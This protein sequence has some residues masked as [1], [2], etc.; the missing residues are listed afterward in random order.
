M[1]AR[2]V[3]PIPA[4]L[5]ALDKTPPPRDVAAV[6]RLVGMLSY[7][8][9]FVDHLADRLQPLYALL[10]KDTPFVWTAAC[11]EAFESVKQCLFRAPTLMLPRP[12]TPFTLK[13]DASRVGPGAVLLQPDPTTGR[14]RPVAFASRTTSPAEQRYS[15]Y[16]SE[17]NAVVFSLRHWRHLLLGGKSRVNIQRLYKLYIFSVINPLPSLRVSEIIYHKP[18]KMHSINYTIYL[19]ITILELENIPQV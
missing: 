11:E 3:R 2:G 10:R 17:L 4:Q 1:S 19:I 16:E 7:F 5:A 9:D 13:T 6:R 8:R 12:S 18:T 15:A 14:L